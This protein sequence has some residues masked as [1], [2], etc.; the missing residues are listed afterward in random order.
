[1]DVLPWFLTKPAKGKTLFL[2]RMGQRG[3]LTDKVLKGSEFTSVWG[4]LGPVFASNKTP[5]SPIFGS[6]LDQGT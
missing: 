4:S 6:F 2:S 1:M 5:C 3:V